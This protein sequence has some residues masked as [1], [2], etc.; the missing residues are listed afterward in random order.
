M[1][2]AQLLRSGIFERG[3]FAAKDE[4]LRFEH[5]AERIQQLLMDGS[6]LALQVQHRDGRARRRWR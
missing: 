1:G 4:L 3:H 2:H 6:I 5:P